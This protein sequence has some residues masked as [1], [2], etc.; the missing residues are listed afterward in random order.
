MIVQVIGLPCSGKTTAIKEFLK[1]NQNI[2]HLDIRNSSNESAFHKLVKRHKNK[3][4]I[5][6]SAT[7]FNIRNSRV[8]RMNTDYTQL[9]NRSLERDKTFDEDY[10]SLLETVMLRTKYTANNKQGLVVLLKKFFKS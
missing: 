6:E 10:L 9:Y 2:T 8:I 7:G 4:I 1:T 5:V 3:N